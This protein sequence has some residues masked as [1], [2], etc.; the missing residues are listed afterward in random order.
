MNA[1]EQEREIQGI[2]EYYISHPDAG[3]QEMLVEMLREFQELLGCIPEGI[4]ERIA[5]ELNIK[6]SVIAYIIKRYPSLKNAAYCHTITVCMGKN[7]IRKNADIL[8]LLK[9]E[10]DVDKDGIS[11]DRTVL[12][13]TKNCLK[14]CR[15]APNIMID[16]AIQSNVTKQSIL[17]E[18]ELR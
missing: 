6:P 2:F 10:L 12:L 7:C 9:K 5:S 3:S 18:L 1:K 8:E 13:R 4:Q 14:H 17:E 16:G 15:T 11:A